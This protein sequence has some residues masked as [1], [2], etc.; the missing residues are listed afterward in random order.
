ME[1]RQKNIEWIPDVE[2]FNIN[3]TNSCGGRKQTDVLYSFFQYMQLEYGYSIKINLLYL[4]AIVI[5]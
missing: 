3:Y 1:I 5:K 2:E 4:N